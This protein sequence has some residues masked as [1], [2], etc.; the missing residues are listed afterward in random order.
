MSTTPIL[1]LEEP[2]PKPPP[3]K[4]IAVPV[5]G[6]VGLLLGLIPTMN[7][8]YLPG[9]NGFLF[10]P[11]LYV[12]VAIHELGHLLVGSLVGMP[13]GALVV[14]GFVI[15]K[16]GQRWLVRFDHRRIFSGGM[17]KPLPQKKDVRPAAFAW[18]IAGGP[19]AS[20]LLTAACA[21]AE[22][23]YADGK[24]N[25]MGTLLWTG[26]L[27]T[28]APWIPGSKRS[29][30]A[31]LRMLIRRPEQSRSWMALWALQTE[32][33]R[34]VVP[35]E[36]DAEL[37]RQMLATDP[38]AAEYPYIQL[39]AFYRCT[40]ENK[41]QEALEHLE[42]ALARS[43]RITKVLRQCIFLE[44]ACSSARSRKNISQARTWIERTGKVHE[45]VSTDGVEAAIAI[46]EKRYEDALRFLGSARVR[47]ERLKLD[48]GLARFAKEKLSED[49]R[50][51]ESAASSLNV[52][53]P[54]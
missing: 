48:S 53:A 43:A 51:C 9:F 45:P 13:P 54:D 39:L 27:I 32:E 24:W 6:L 28:I 30:G 1:D 23:R 11:A 52:L 31:R 36:W 7:L 38:S 40:D 20:V 10:L 16:S 21:L 4:W 29:D 33:T 50:L 14:G 41:E 8:H 18:M 2:P 37:V 22:F 5:G 46:R 35:R 3:V 12:S 49:Q 47:I 15:F 19:I 17:A 26:L 34:G 44:A 25:W 42:N